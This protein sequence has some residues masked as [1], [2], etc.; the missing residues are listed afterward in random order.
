[1]QKDFFEGRLIQDNDKFMI[2]YA[3]MQFKKGTPKEGV[4]LE[5][6]ITVT[7]EIYAEFYDKYPLSNVFKDMDTNLW[8]R[9][10]K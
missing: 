6:Y 7:K 5:D 10:L 2:A 9:Y 1:M 3:K 8:Y 4:T